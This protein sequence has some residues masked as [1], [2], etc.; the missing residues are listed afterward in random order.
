MAAVWNLYPIY[1]PKATQRERGE[2]EKSF[3]FFFLFVLLEHNLNPLQNAWGSGEKHMDSQICFWCQRPVDE[4]KTIEKRE[5]EKIKT[6][7]KDKKESS[8]T[9][10]R[11]RL[12]LLKC[13]TFLQGNYRMDFFGGCA[14][15]W[16][17]A[18]RG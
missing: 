8:K 18:W 13:N 9:N 16:K 2:R 5:Q 3:F 15:C 4:M 1:N 12:P 10:A 14:G 7:R 6:L 11:Y 17:I